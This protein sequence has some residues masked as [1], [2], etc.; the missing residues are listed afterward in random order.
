MAAMDKRLEEYFSQMNRRVERLKERDP[1]KCP[2]CGS[3]VKKEQM[4]KSEEV[5]GR[6]RCTE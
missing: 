4:G 3:W 6:P 1:V 5:P 2:T